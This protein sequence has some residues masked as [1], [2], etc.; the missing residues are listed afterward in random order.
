MKFY[1]VSLLCR[2]IGAGIVPARKSASEELDSSRQISVPHLCVG[3]QALESAANSQMAGKSTGHEQTLQKV[4][5]G[6]K[7][8]TTDGAEASL[9]D[10]GNLRGRA[11]AWAS[12]PCGAGTS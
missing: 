12:V 2:D 10:S 5:A 7:T 3:G 1:F 4:H 9:N 8:H 6:E 11:Y